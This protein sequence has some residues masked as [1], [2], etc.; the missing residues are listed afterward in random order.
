MYKNRDPPKTASL[1]D[2]WKNF[3][4]VEIRS[5]YSTDFEMKTPI[6]VQQNQSLRVELAFIDT[7]SLTGQGGEPDGKL[8][9]FIKYKDG[10]DTKT[11]D[12]Y[13]KT[14]CINKDHFYAYLDIPQDRTDKY[15]YFVMR[16]YAGLKDKIYLGSLR[17]GSFILSTEVIESSKAVV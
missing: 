15:A 13:C 4:Q 3:T 1:S 7:D 16:G 9:F 5:G 12:F 6:S 8:H 2:D 17:L 11:T 14:D 10:T